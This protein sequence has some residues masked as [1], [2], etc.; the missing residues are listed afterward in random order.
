[1]G[2]WNEQGV[3]LI[4]DAYSNQISTFF[5]EVRYIY[6]FDDIEIIDKYVT[7][8]NFKYDL[9]IKDGIYCVVKYG[10]KSLFIVDDFITIFE[11]PNYEDYSL[12]EVKNKLLSNE[13]I[14]EESN[15]I[16]LI[17]NISIKDNKEKQKIYLF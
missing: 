17:N 6:N 9:I 15:S 4:S 5:N 11:E 8:H 2:R 16:S 3:K 1:M 7:E 14:R 13:E 10:N 12:Q